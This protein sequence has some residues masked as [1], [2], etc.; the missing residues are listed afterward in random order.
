MLL[1]LKESSFVDK[2]LVNNILSINMDDYRKAYKDSIQIVNNYLYRNNIINYTTTNFIKIEVSK[3]S[4]VLG[5]FDNITFNNI[6]QI[7]KDY[8]KDNIEDE[9]ENTLFSPKRH[10]NIR[11]RG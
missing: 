8:V 7:S 1:K 5:E 3:H 11:N 2:K 4:E 10:E 6:F 9:K